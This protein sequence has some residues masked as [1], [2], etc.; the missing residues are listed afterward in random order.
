MNDLGVLADLVL[1]SGKHAHINPVDGL[2]AF[3]SGAEGLLDVAIKGVPP[4]GRN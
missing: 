4:G 2:D 3:E 1:D